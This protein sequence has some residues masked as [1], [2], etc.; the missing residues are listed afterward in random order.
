MSFSKL[1]PEDI[2]I[3]TDSI[4]AP[5]WSNNDISL[6]S[7]YQENSS[8]FSY[9]NV[10]AQDPNISSS[11][12]TQFSIMYGH[13]QGSGSALINPLVSTNSLSRI[14]YG[15]MRTLINGDENT[16]IN[17]GTGNTESPD[18]YVININR[19]RY[20]EK[21]FLPT[22]NI[23][24]NNTSG[25]LQLTNNSKDITSV[26]YCDAGR[27][28]DIV[29][30]SSGNA[31][32]SSSISGVSA[33]Y[34]ISGSYGKFLPDVGLILLNPQA[35][36]LP[37]ISGGLD[38]VLGTSDSNITLYQNNNI[39]F[40]LINS[41]SSFSLNSEETI[42]SDYIFVRPKNAEFN[43]TTNPSIINSDGEFYYDTFINNPQTYI[44]TIGLYN[45]DNELLAVAKLSK[46]LVKDFN[47]EALIRVK[48]DF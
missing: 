43:Y 5:L 3:S 6:Q 24:L 14:I 47:K 4:V 28:F 21:L 37:F 48:L 19:A 26:T 32:V 12:D 7:I 11:L 13:A 23:L 2:T 29:S 34:T 30:G 27:V 33:G 42:T 1:N 25:T 15:Q 16:Y 18:L 35:L 31:I 44:T 9:I 10:Y 40:N 20:K 38:V 36:Q 8:S 46:P 45:D 41:G 39:L 22:F 17:F